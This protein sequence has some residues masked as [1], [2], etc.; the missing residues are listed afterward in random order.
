MINTSSLRKSIKAFGLDDFDTQEIVIPRPDLPPLPSWDSFHNPSQRSWAELLPDM[1]GVSGVFSEEAIPRVRLVTRL[2]LFL[3]NRR[4]WFSS[5]D[6]VRQLLEYSMPGNAQV[7]VY[8]QR[9]DRFETVTGSM[10]PGD[11]FITGARYPRQFHDR[12]TWNHICE[13]VT[14]RTINQE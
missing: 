3:M 7:M 11:V 2:E 14:T 9:R 13:V 5:G 12:E 8:N 6:T 1:S 10:S 4:S